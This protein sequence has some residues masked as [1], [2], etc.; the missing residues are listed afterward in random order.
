MAL[1]NVAVG[2]GG[3][4]VGGI[5]SMQTPKMPAFLGTEKYKKPGFIGRKVHLLGIVK[6]E[7]GCK[8]ITACGGE[9]AFV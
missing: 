3:G 2:L 1:V 4:G 8:V 9:P 7:V 6:T 5:P